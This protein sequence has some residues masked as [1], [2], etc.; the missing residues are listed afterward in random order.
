MCASPEA[1]DHYFDILEITLDQNNL[2]SKPCQIY[3]AYEILL[4]NRTS[5]SCGVLTLEECM[6]LGIDLS[7]EGDEIEPG[8][9][10]FFLLNSILHYP[11]EVTNLVFI[12]RHSLSE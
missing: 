6:S 11:K 7:L 9:R 12:D 4:C 8:L 1:L 2:S 10:F 3:Y 5:I